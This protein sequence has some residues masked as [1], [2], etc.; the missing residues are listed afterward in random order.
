MQPGKDNPQLALENMNKY[1]PEDDPRNTKIGKLLRLLELDEIPQL[2]QV[3]AGKLSLFDIRCIADYSIDLIQQNR[4]KSFNEWEKAYSEGKPG[5]IGLNAVMNPDRKNDL[6]RHHYD[7]LYAK[8]ANLGL[9]LYILYRSII[10]ALNKF[11][12]KINKRNS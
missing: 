2:F 9:D 5:L 3:L 10:Y 1:A 4:P 11:K 6:K 12:R 8:K 7:I